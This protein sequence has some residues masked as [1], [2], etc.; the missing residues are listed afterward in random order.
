LYA[1][2]TGSELVPFGHLPYLP[3]VLPVQQRAGSLR[4]L[5]AKEARMQAI[6]GFSEW[7]S[8]AETTW[9]KI[10]GKKAEYDLYEWLDYEGKLTG[11]NLRA[12]YRVVFPGPSSTYLVAAVLPHERQSIKLEKA[13][14]P[15]GG[16][17][18]DHALLRY[19]TEDEDEAYYLC[20]MLNAT[21]IDHTI[22]PFQSTGKGGAQNIHK[23]PL[24]LPIPRYN[25]R[26]PL[27]R[28]LL[29][30]GK[31]CAKIVD[32]ELTSIA[33]TYEGIGTIRR[34]VKERISNQLS[35]IDNL[36]RKVLDQEKKNSSLDS[37]LP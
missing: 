8:E 26:N 21:S 25:M 9:Q 24:E 31:E 10:R 22:K 15:L 32:A 36:A 11:Q 14:V 19:E 6:E 3:V 18:I 4:I 17:V 34:L 37:R 30:L 16:L 1:A 2:I 35:A 27:H 5:T 7:F 33:S 13:T 29:K 28:E 23:K 20:S 12:K